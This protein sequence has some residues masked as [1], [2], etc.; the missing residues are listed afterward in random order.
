M[1]G[2]SRRVAVDVGARGRQ[3][4]ELPA[5][6][7]VIGGTQFI[8]RRCVEELVRLGVDVTMI[9]RGKTP[10]PHPT[11]SVQHVVCD[12]QVRLSVQ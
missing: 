6:V 7:L 5:C 8:G 10:N 1:Q 9:T 3:G 4:G 11:E 2:K 12:R